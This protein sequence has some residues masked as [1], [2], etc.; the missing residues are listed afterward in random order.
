MTKALM[1]S[2][3]I[4]LTYICVAQTI[5]IKYYKSARLGKTVPKITAKFS[6]TIIQNTDSSITTEFK[7]LKTNKILYSYTYKGD[8]PCGKWIYNRHDT[9]EELDY[10]FKVKYGTSTCAD[11]TSGIEIYSLRKSAEKIAD[12]KIIGFKTI[13]E[14]ESKNFVY[15]TEVPSSY[16]LGDV[17]VSFNLTEKD[18]AEDIVVV[19]GGCVALDKEAV[20]LIRK[21]K[22]QSSQSENNMTQKSCVVVLIS[23]HISTHY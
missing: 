23:Y 1:T 17:Y 4:L 9:I 15:L 13:F 16:C 12:R 5:Q 14:F 20:R 3:F 22:F 7:N 19:K 11:S 8:E 10:S 18:H 21:L 6:R 2:T